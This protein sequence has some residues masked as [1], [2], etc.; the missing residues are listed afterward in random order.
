MYAY[1]PL[2][3]VPVVLYFTLLRPLSRNASIN[4]DYSI[5]HLTFYHT[6]TDSNLYAAVFHA[7]TYCYYYT[8]S[9][10]PNKAT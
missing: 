9:D 3:R 5:T 1:T 4:S 8:I 10:T 7:N 2:K 6:G